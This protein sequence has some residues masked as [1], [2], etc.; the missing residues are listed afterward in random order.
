MNPSMYVY[1]ISDYHVVVQR[2]ERSRT[3]GYFLVRREDSVRLSRGF[4]LCMGFSSKAETLRSARV[5][6]AQ[7]MFKNLSV[8][9]I[10]DALACLD[11]EDKVNEAMMLHWMTWQN[12]YAIWNTLGKGSAT[13]RIMAN[14]KRLPEE[15][16]YNM[17]L[18][19]SL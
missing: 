9:G 1:D 14:D 17:N 7:N 18:F 6:V 5:H 2:I 8:R 4:G 3:W 12:I 11:P 15:H 16:Q 13:C 10:E 19:P